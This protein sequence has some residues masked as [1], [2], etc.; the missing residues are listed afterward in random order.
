MTHGRYTSVA[1]RATSWSGSQFWQ[2]KKEVPL[3][4]NVPIP[5]RRLQRSVTWPSLSPVCT[6][7]DGQPVVAMIPSECSASSSQSMRGFTS[8]TVKQLLLD[9]VLAQVNIV[10]VDQELK[11]L[12]ASSV[13]AVV[14]LREGR[15][16]VGDRQRQRQVAHDRQDRRRPGQCRCDQVTPCSHGT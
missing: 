4:E 9:G 6:S 15:R 7:P 12:L 10:N 8:I 1:R 5:G 2:L 13:A 3:P 16:H 11:Q 14:G